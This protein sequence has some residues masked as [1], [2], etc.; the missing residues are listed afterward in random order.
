MSRTG[1]NS[2]VFLIFHERY[3]SNSCFL[4]TTQNLPKPDLNYWALHAVR[5]SGKVKP[6]LTQPF[7]VRNW[8]NLLQNR[9]LYPV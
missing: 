5:L 8:K 1:R 7:T 4:I 3:T 9:L 2:A 6:I